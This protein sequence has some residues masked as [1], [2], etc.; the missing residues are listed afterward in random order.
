MGDPSLLRGV[1]F[2]DYTMHRDQ[3]AQTKGNETNQ[4][5]PDRLE[6]GNEAD[7]YHGDEV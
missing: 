6:E 1:V 5:G 3:K 4:G 7:K 2:K